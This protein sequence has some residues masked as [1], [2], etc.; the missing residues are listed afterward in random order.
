[1][2]LLSTRTRDCIGSRTCFVLTSFLALLHISCEARS[3]LFYRHT[4]KGLGSS[5]TN[6]VDSILPSHTGQ[7]HT[8]SHIFLCEEDFMHAQ[9]LSHHPQP[10]T[11]SFV[12]T[13]SK[14]IHPENTATS[15]RSTRSKVAPS[16]TCR[17]RPLPMKLC[18]LAC[19]TRTRTQV[20][21]LTCFPVVSS[22]LS[23]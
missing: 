4:R 11:R 10:Q 3:N 20:I 12:P 5:P 16:F 22:F 7:H 17:V 1:M 13:S 2:V 9:V 18:T 15:H 23:V 6:K 19:G 8:S 21:A 14:L